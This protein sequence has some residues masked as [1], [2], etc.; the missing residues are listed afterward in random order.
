MTQRKT[1]ARMLTIAGSDSGG[2]AGIQA[3]VKAAS[4]CGCF[5]ATAITSLTVQNTLGVKA[6]HVPPVE[7]VAGQVS[8]VLED[9]GADAVKL[10]MLPTAE[11]VEAVTD[12]LQR[13]RITKIVLDPV[14]VATSGDKLISDEAVAAIVRRL[15]PLAM[16]VTPN[17][18]EAEYITGVK[19]A[20]EADFP[21]AVKRFF[22]LGAQNVLLKAGHLTGQTTLTDRLYT[23]GGGEYSFSYD[24]IDTPNT[25]GTGCTL[26]SSIAAYLAQGHDLPEAVALAEEYVHKAILCG[27]DYTL[28]CGHGPLHHFYKFW[29]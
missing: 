24:F 10:G 9:I 4:A 5:A 6:V 15:L 16:L 7:V 1:Y 17:I 14:M 18:P 19:I 2:C 21:S 20:S 12:E 28:G 11:I 25:H 26:S 3:D 22:E 23:A 13:F 27:A 8:A 29:E